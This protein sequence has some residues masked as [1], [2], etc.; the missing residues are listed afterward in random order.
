VVL[1]L[2]VKLAQEKLVDGTIVE[3]ESFEPGFPIFVVTENGPTIP[4]MGEHETD[5]LIIVTD[6]QGIITEVREKEAEAPEAEVEVEIEA[7]AEEVE[8][9]VKEDLE[10]DKDYKE[11]MKKV[12]EMVEEMMKEV[13]D[14][15][16]EMASMKE[17]FNKF[18]AEPGAPKA[19]SITK[20]DVDGFNVAEAR[21]EALQK[22]KQQNFFKK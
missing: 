14:I 17:K 7:A 5:T 13:A 21:A 22:L 2:E 1:G 9:E 4:P 11:S 6:E 3:A 12:V 18:S 10:E 20:G 15:K 16:T 8:V 19:P